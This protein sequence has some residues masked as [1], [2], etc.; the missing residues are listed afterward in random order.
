MTDIKPRYF[1]H[2]DFCIRF[3]E[4]Q[5][6]EYIFFNRD[7]NKHYEYFDAYSQKWHFWSDYYRG[8]AR[9]SHKQIMGLIVAGAYKSMDDFYNAINELLKPRKLGKALKDAKMRTAQAAFQLEKYGED[10]ID[11]PELFRDARRVAKLIADTGKDENVF[12]DQFAQLLSVYSAD[13]L[14]QGQVK[15][16]WTFLDAQVEKHLKLDR[17]EAAILDVDNK[18]LYF[19]WGKIKRECPKGDTFAW[20]IKLASERCGCS[21]SNVGPIMQKL[22]KLGAVTLIQAGKAG[23]HSGRAAIYRR[24]V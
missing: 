11:N 6:I 12:A 16:I 7:Y 10:F 2:P 23:R 5:A 4:W 14:T 1:D 21:K 24:E 8:H 13:E 3:M 22:E 15:T 20:P 17:V 19:M 18:N 9:E